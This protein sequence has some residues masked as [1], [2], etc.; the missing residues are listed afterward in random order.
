M[1]SPACTVMYSLQAVTNGLPI[2]SKYSQLYSEYS[3]RNS[4][5]AADRKLS[6]PAER[7]AC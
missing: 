6:V 2:C 1:S 3:D 5:R 7:V 4:M